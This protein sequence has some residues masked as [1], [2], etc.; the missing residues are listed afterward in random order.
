MKIFSNF[1]HEL[2]EKPAFPVVTV[3]V[4][5]GL[6]QGHQKILA[7]SLE[8]AS[9]APVALVTFDPH[10]RA[11]LGPPKH[12]RLLSPIDERLELMG[13]WPVSAVA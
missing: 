8:V 2:P 4:F 9:G 13:R 11:V 12:G 1:P 5:D 10:P 7:T 3:G 6:H